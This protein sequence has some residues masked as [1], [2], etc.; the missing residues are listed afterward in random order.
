MA[1]DKERETSFGEDGHLAQVCL[2]FTVTG[3]FTFEPI[4]LGLSH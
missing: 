4:G 2:L 3:S 1:S